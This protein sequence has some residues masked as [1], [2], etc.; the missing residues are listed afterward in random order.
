[1]SNLSLTPRL[2]AVNVGV[3]W[4]LTVSTVFLQQTVETVWENAAPLST[5]MNRGVNE[6]TCRFVF[7]SRL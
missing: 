3:S 7:F 4:P 1:M 2:I 5:A 6:K